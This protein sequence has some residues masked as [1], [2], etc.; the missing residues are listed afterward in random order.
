MSS[1]VHRL[2]K[3]ESCHELVKHN[4]AP[5]KSE[6]KPNIS[7]M[8]KRHQKSILQF[9]YKKKIVHLQLSLKE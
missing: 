5:Q 7:T 9:H 8:P 2:Q 1:Q 3:S 4:S 6:Q